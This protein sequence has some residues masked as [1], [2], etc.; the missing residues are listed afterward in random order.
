MPPRPFVRIRDSTVG[1]PSSVN[2]FR[3]RLWI[4]A[5]P[6]AR[7]AGTVTHALPPPAIGSMAV[8]VAGSPPLEL[9]RR[10]PRWRSATESGWSRS[11]FCARKRA[12]AAYPGQV[13]V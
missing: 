8:A 2:G 11:Q 10:V 13:C 4:V 5:V 6:L 1:I 7:F 3:K 9:M 12:M